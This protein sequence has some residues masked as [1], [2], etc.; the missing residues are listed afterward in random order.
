MPEHTTLPRATA[1][2]QAVLAAYSLTS[3][4]LASAWHVKLP[5]GIWWLNACAAVVGIASGTRVT[6]AQGNR[7]WNHIRRDLFRGLGLGLLL[8]ALSQL[9]IYAVLLRI[10]AARVELYRLYGLL[11]TYPGPKWASP[12]LLGVVVAEELVFRG[13][14]TTWLAQRHRPASSLALSTLLYV[15]PMLASG[16]WLL[17]V[18]GL[19]LGAVW[20]WTRQQSQGLTLPLVSHAVFS[21]ASFAWLP[22]R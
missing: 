7:L 21:L 17:C 2:T 1:S 4:T 20:T 10:P 22:L 5:S 12:V 15:L 9:A 13:A 18:L 19:S 11:S 16:S 14:V 3:L 8:V 6:R